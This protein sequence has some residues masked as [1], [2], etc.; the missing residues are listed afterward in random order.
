LTDQPKC[1][2]PCY[3]TRDGGSKDE[4][5]EPPAERADGGVQPELVVKNVRRGLRIQVASDLHLEF[6]KRRFP[7]ERVI[8]PLPDADLLVLAGDIDVGLGVFEA[9][10]DWPVPVLYLIGNHES[11]GREYNEDRKI[12]RAASAGT[13]IVFLDQDLVTAGDLATR[14]PAWA[15]GRAA[16]LPNV[17]FMGCTLWTG[18]RYTACGKSHEAQMD[19]A[20]RG[21]NDHRLIRL[22]TGAFDARA[23]LACHEADCDWLRSE[24]GKPFTGDTIVITHHAPC[25]RSVHPRFQGDPLTGAFVTD[26]P[27]LLAQAQIWIHGHQH[28]SSDYVELGCRVVCNPSGYPTGLSSVRHAGELHFENTEFDGQLIIELPSV[29]G[30]DGT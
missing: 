22:S 7:G 30:G 9:F 18:Y 5:Q 21:L 11:Y 23:A 19:V 3:S 28:N 24:L 12:L 27:D 1:L 14:F 13:N 20:E 16:A 17:R 8:R 10:S 15:S 26:L 6:I 2:S 4:K 25:E 29:Q